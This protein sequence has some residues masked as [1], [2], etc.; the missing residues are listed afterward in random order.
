[1]ERGRGGGEEGRG[2][3]IC[4]SPVPKKMFFQCYLKK[5]V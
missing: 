3:N 4:G 1:M 2:V 5:L